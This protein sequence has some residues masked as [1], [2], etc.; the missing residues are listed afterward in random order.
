[1]P[2]AKGTPKPPNSGRKKGGGNKPTIAA[3]LAALNCDPITGLAALAMD[4][5]NKPEVRARCYAELLQYL[6]PKKRSIEQRFV[7]QD[8]NDREALDLA[9]VRA[10]MQSVDA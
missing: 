1:M 4:T 7:D 8:G 10:Y 2:F 9:S 6:H 3:A 5:A